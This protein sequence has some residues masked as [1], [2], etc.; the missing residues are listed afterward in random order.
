MEQHT[1]PPTQLDPQILT[2]EKIV[3]FAG[4]DWWYHNPHSNKHL[5]QALAR[6]GNKV[7]FVNSTGVRAPNLFR[8]RFAW[9]RIA[10]KLISMLI[11]LARAEP[12]LHVLTPIALPV[13]RRFRRLVLRLNQ[14]LIAAQVRL[15]C[16]L[17]G[18]SQPIIWIATPAA[19]RA[20]I[21]LRR[22]WAKL[23]VYYCVD[24]VSFYSGADTPFIQ[25]LDAH[26]QSR[27]D[28]ILFSGRRLFA[29]RVQQRSDIY[30]LPHGVDFD[31]FARAHSPAHL[32]PNDLRALSQPIA[33]F[34]GAITGLDVQLIDYVARR[35]PGVSFVFIGKVQMD[36]SRL[37]P[38]KNVHFLGKKDYEVL[39]DYLGCFRC[40][41][42]CYR[43]GDTFNEY[44]SPKKLFEYFTSGRPLVSVQL[45]ELDAFPTLV[46]QAANAQEFDEQL[47]AAL[48]EDDP[49]LR[50]LRI[51][52]ARARD[53][54][55]VAA[56]AS[57]HISRYLRT[58][59]DKLVAADQALQSSS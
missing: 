5:M 50:R 23:L 34:I 16:A 37:A 59:R 3:C 48:A 42:I 39:P 10:R 56:E 38:L 12:G 6:N 53:W 28:L 25:Q 7:L 1:A 19:A 57:Q 36:V 2:G 41:L 11:F 31:H 32:M 44:R 35:Q 49:E 14:I 13:T 45:A 8:D 52:V 20:A 43:R 15:C 18:I 17:L 30:L 40:C 47:R 54:S 29:E 22:K 33:A 46:Y 21:G 9:Q 55:V 24:N 4:E 58:G 26:L 51:E 27:A